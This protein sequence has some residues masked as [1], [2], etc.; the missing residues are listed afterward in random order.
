MSRASLD[1]SLPSVTMRWTANQPKQQ[2]AS[3]RPSGRVNAA[4]ARPSDAASRPR[5]LLPYTLRQTTAATMELPRLQPTGRLHTAK[6]ALLHSSPSAIQPTSPRFCRE[7]KR[8]THH[9]IAAMVP[10]V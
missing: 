9:N 8:A 4:A 5:R 3:S 7:G 6:V 2:A 10:M 1:L